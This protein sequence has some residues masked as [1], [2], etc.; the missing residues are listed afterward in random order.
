MKSGYSYSFN[1]HWHV[2]WSWKQMLFGYSIEFKNVFILSIA[3]FSL[4][5]IR[6]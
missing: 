6:K 1:R 2:C 5:W 4:V 3:F